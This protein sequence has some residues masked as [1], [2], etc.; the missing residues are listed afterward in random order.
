MIDNKA[1]WEI[2]GFSETNDNSK[3]SL[4]GTFFT[5]KL[6]VKFDFKNPSLII[7]SLFNILCKKFCLLCA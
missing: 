6:L 5:L 4:L 1:N 3:T 2:L 7:F